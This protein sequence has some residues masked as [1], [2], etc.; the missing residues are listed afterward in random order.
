MS[1]MRNAVARRPHK[2]RSQPKAREKWGILEKHKDY[3]LR[4]RD[5]NL[6]KQKLAI[7]SQKARNRNEDEFAFGMLS[8]NKAQAGK[9]GRG[10]TQ[11][12]RLSHDAV[13]LL[14]SQDAGYLRIVAGRGRKEI[15]KLEEDIVMTKPSENSRK[16]LF[17]EEDER[18]N[19][20]KGRV[21][22]RKK[23]S[24]EVAAAGSNQEEQEEQEVPSL[25][26]ENIAS[27]TGTTVY[28]IDTDSSSTK[29]TAPTSKK[30]LAAQRDAMRDLRA[31]R[32]RRKRLAELRVARLE[33]LKKRQREIMAAADELE[34]Q[35]AKMARTVGGVNKDGVKWKIRERKR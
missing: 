16:V 32:K 5:Y 35:R 11:A 6:K 1:S 28:A 8:A 7:L 29:P 21:E 4:A 9:H 23:P 31:A 17:V 2:E 12:N 18:L 24:N 19:G 3:S 26:I 34:L 33:A 14:K 27:V 10:D 15:S 25:G 13:K 22:R 20:T 30:A